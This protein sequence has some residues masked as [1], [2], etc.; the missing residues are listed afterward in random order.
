MPRLASTLLRRAYASDPLLLLLLRECRDLD[1]ARNELRWLRE[2]VHSLSKANACND[3]WRQRQLKSMVRDRARGMPL[4]YI[5][6]DQPFGELDILCRKGVLIPRPETE[7]YTFRTAR[8]IL[9]ELRMGSSSPAPIRILDLCTGTGCIP[10]LLHSLLAS[11]IPDLALVGIDISRKA[12]SLA[13]ENLEYNISQNH[14]LPRA[15]QDISFLQANVLR[16][17]KAELVKREGDAIPSLQAVLA[18]FESAADIRNSRK[19]LRGQWDVLIS[20]PP[21]I[22][23]VDFCNGTTRRSVRLHEPTLALVPPPLASPQTLETHKS[24]YDENAMITAQ[25]DSFY[26][27]LLDISDFIGAKLTVLECGDPAQA[28]RIVDLVVRRNASYPPARGL[29]ARIWKCDHF[30]SDDMFAST[31]KHT[32]DEEDGGARAVVIYRNRDI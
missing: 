10:L 1:S 18:D 25:Q 21:Y 9:S 26:P 32:D 2:H 14:L 7:S 28:R 12:L 31:E 19:D 4:Q 30:G 13:R 16:D 29:E 3:A 8:L 6:G 5:L 27:R 15:R 22:S 11:S 20:N 24:E 23:P 17:E